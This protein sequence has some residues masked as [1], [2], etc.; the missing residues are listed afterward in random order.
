MSAGN[1]VKDGTGIAYWLL[2]DALGRLKIN[3]DWAPS[4][5]ADENL[6]DSDKTFTVTAAKVWEI[7]WIWV[8]FTSDGTAGSRQLTVELQDSLPDVIFQMRAGIVQAQSLTRYYLFAPMGA[9]IVAFRDTDFLYVPLPPKIVL[10][11][12]YIIRV[13]DKAAIA[14][15]TDDMI[16]QMMVNQKSA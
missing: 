3:D 14:A 9:E 12:S 6:N 16:V 1:T 5:Q 15:A 4:L 2:V 7:L 10:P 11:A 13:Y 8:E